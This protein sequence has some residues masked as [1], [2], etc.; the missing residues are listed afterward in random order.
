M[1]LNEACIQQF[2]HAFVLSFVVG[3]LCSPSYAHAAKL[4]LSNGD[5]LSGEVVLLRNEALTLKSP[6]YG[7]IELPWDQVVQ[8]ES[9]QDTIIELKGGKRVEGKL[10]LGTDGTVLIEKKN[11]EVSSSL[12]REQIAQLNPPVI[13]NVIQYSGR[14]N[15]G[16]TFN[17][18][19]SEDDLLNLDAEFV[20]RTLVNRYTLGLEVNEAK[21]SGIRSTSQRLLRTQYDVF[22]NEKNYLFAGVQAESDKFEDLNLRASLGGGYGRQFFETQWTKLAA[23]VSLNFV[24]EDYMM[25]QDD[26][27]PSLGL[28]LKFDKKMMGGKLI[29]FNN[30]NSVINLE[31]MSGYL[32]N[33]RLGLR[34]PVSDR[35]NVTSQLNVDYDNLTPPNVKKTD[36]S[37][38]FSV[39]YGF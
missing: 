17:R 31:H 19:N 32:L 39:G 9:D 23:E 35:L 20:A 24:H 36:A 18:G 26:S 28:G 11:L 33:T 27:F 12:S 34:V 38:V 14:A 37:L 8:L 21:T 5:Q 16:G 4:V 29:V 7:E 1:L 3:V 15:L 22:V 2:F 30:Y 25:A 13:E 6:V 10:L